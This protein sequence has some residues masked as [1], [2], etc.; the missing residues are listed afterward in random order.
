MSRTYLAMHREEDLCGENGRIVK[1]LGLRY[2][3]Q[4]SSNT[5][6]SRFAIIGTSIKSLKSNTSFCS[7]CI[8]FSNKKTNCWM[9]STVN[10]L[11]S[12]W[13]ETFCILSLNIYLQ[14]SIITHKLLA[15]I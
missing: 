11:I 7:A 5:C 15:V 2:F 14:R 12:S 10:L 4:I 3:L 6:G 9:I 13:V 8:M 1:F